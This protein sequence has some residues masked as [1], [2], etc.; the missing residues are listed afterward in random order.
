MII[1][2]L[3]YIFFL[4]DDEKQKEEKIRSKGS[5]KSRTAYDEYDS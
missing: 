4:F 2:E 1:A 3:K 5:V